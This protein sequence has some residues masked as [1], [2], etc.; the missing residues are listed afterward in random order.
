MDHIAGTSQTKQLRRTTFQ[1]LSEKFIDANK[2]YLS[3]P[4]GTLLILRH[5]DMLGIDDKKSNSAEE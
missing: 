1:M 5:F 3:C 4:T 2:G